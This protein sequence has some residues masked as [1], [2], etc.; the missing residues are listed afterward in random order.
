MKSSIT[1]VIKILIRNLDKRFKILSTNKGSYFSQ[2]TN[3]NTNP[4]ANIQLT[5]NIIKS[6]N[7]SNTNMSSTITHQKEDDNLRSTDSLEDINKFDEFISSYALVDDQL[8]KAKK[9]DYD[10]IRI[11]LN[12]EKLSCKYVELSSNRNMSESTID[13]SELNEISIIIKQD[14]LISENIRGEDIEDI[15]ININF[16]PLP[17]HNIN[18]LDDYNYNSKEEEYLGNDFLNLGKSIKK[19]QNRR[20]R[21]GFI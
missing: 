2:C 14:E 15:N 8:K 11:E 13:K 6:V 4:N 5:N 21:G 17:V 12:D 1:Q 3:N 16:M 7:E 10:K 19:G 18:S 9:T 20:K